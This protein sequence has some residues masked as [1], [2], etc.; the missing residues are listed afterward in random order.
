MLLP[1]AILTAVSRCLAICALL[2]ALSIPVVV[3]AQTG[4]PGGIFDPLP[5][6][7]QPPENPLTD[8]KA[9]LG[10]FLFWEEQLSHDNSTSCGTCHIPEAGGSDPR[11][12][13]SR[14]IHPGYDGIFGNADDVVGSIGVVLQACGG[15]TIDDGVF[16][17]ERQVTGRR[18]PS[19]IA[20]GYHPTLFWDGR[21]G[22][23]FVDPETGQV[24]IPVGGALEA[25][26]VAPILSMVEMGCD[27]LGWDSVRQKMMAITPLA[28]AT[29]LPDDLIDGLIQFSDYPALFDNA[30][31]DP[32]ISAARIAFAIASYERT[33]V[34]DRTPFDLFNEGINDA[35]TE[36]Q[37]LGLLLFA[38]NCLPCHETPAL[39]DGSFRNIGV[40]PAFED[41]GLGAV[42]GDPEHAGQFKSPSLRNVG[43]RAPYF[44]NGGKADL[45]EVL[46]FYNG[47]GDFAPA[48]PLIVEMNLPNSELAQIK[49]FLEQG[50]TDP[51][52][53]FALPPFDHP[54]MQPFFVR[55]D[56]NADGAVDISDA[57]ASLQFLFT[58]GVI[59]CED[60]SDSNDDGTIDIADPVALLA[61]LFVGAAPLPAPSDISFGPDP[62]PDS[63][64]CLY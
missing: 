19:F 62:T 12:Q 18:S 43:L 31:G 4:G 13:Q 35:L 24:L 58:G 11:V 59:L 21:A 63:L 33:L 42:T 26:A 56:S 55:G 52:V 60:A 14:S 16:F 50:L 46:A 57:I 20:A 34:P 61:R 17:P 23:E 1:S 5:P 15:D 47:G 51:R 28:L 41:E 25:Q 44:H 7:P 29:D 8:Q 6:M 30:F 9:L 10:K 32:E 3:P 27:T 40:R 45:D 54:T 64:A 48:D 37:Q 22:P 53:E 2:A 49:D 36:N 39:G 38:D